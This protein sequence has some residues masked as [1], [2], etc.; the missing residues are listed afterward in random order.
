MHHNGPA[1][2]ALA[3]VAWPTTD[4]FADRMDTHATT[5]LASVMQDR[6]FTTLRSAEGKTY[7]ASVS[8]QF[9]MRL[10][11]Y[12]GLI[13]MAQV[14]P[15]DVGAFFATFDGIAAD[16]VAHGISDDEFARA[17]KPHIEQTE[18]SHQ[19]NDF[20]LG[21]M[22]RAQN[23]PRPLARWATLIDEFKALKKADVEAAAKRWLVKSKT[24]RAEVLPQTA[25]A[26]VT[27]A[28]APSS[29]PGH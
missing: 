4:A 22:A 9:S 26:T 28:P 17:V 8:S 20:W 16:I 2:Q 27:P 24:W 29:P 18:R 13:A 25:T 15:E 7:G 11:G 14:A 5:V 1:Y 21:V 12:G 10:P 6:A 19:G 23:D 3:V